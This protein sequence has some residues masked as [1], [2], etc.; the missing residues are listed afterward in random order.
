M[1]LWISSYPKSGNTWIRALISTYLY[2]D[3][4]NFEFKLLHKIPKFIQEKF[5]SINGVGELNEVTD[6]LI[7]TIDSKI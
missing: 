1:I 5:I 3:D 7:S 2:S 4:G 6:R